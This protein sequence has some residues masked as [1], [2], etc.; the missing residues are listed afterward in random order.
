MLKIIVKILNGYKEYFILIFFLL[1]SL[2]LLSF[3]Q[4]TGFNKLKSYAFGTFAYFSSTIETVKS[5]VQDEDEIIRLQKQNARLLLE[6][7]KLRSYAL[8]NSELKSLLSFKDSISHPLIPARVISKSNSQLFHSLIINI[9]TNQG[10]ETGMPVINH[11]GLVG[12]ISDVSSSFSIVRTIMD[13]NLRVAVE[14][15]RTGIYGILAWDGEN[16]LIKN[17]VATTEIDKGDRVISSSFSTLVPPAIP[18]GVVVETHDKSKKILGNVVIKSYVDFNSLKNL[19][20]I[21]VIE[22]TSVNRLKL[23]YIKLN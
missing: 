21:K 17:I 23:N 13:Q 9:G 3:K 14:I 2:Y 1:L 11:E 18:V 15:Q 12:I 7:N 19:F 6:V 20:V 5:F 10:I 4:S 16:N 22:D 8:E